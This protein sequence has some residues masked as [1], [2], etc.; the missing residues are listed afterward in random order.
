[1]VATYL[2]RRSGQ[3][4]AQLSNFATTVAV[5]YA[6]IQRPFDVGIFVQAERA[7]P[8]VCGRHSDYLSCRELFVPAVATKATAQQQQQLRPTV[9]GLYHHDQL[10]VGALVRRG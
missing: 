10:P 2:P 8:S 7:S 4:G 5:G 9:R 6:T 3:P 1:M